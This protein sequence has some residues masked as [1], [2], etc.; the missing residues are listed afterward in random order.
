M[1]IIDAAARGSLKGVKRALEEGADINKGSDSHNDTALIWAAYR[2]HPLIVKYLIENG[3]DTTITNNSGHTA[4]SLAKSYNYKKVV[5]L[6]E[7]AAHKPQESWRKMGVS[8]IAHHGTYPDINQCLTTV[9]NFQSRDRYIIAKPLDDE[10]KQA[11]SASTSFD[12]LPGA[13][14]EEALKHFERLGGKADRDYVLLG[15]E[16]LDKPKAKLSLG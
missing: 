6:L 3:A 14:V 5:D 9:F 7:K 13:A 2:N 15:R 8:T 16:S 12:S 1:D 11:V 10:A 4:L